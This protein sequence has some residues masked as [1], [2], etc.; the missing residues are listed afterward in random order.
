MHHLV[1]FYKPSGHA[2]NPHISRIGSTR[3]IF[4]LLQVTFHFRSGIIIYLHQCSLGLY[5]RPVYQTCGFYVLKLIILKPLRISLV[6]LGAQTNDSK[7][8]CF[9]GLTFLTLM[10][11]SAGGIL[12]PSHVF[13]GAPLFHLSLPPLLLSPFPFVPLRSLPTLTFPMYQPRLLLCPSISFPDLFP[14]PV[15]PPIFLIFPT[16]IQACYTHSFG[17][18]RASR[19][20]G[21]C[22]SSVYSFEES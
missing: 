7:W 1:I 13:P 12:I 2:P 17:P 18:Q 14:F 15:H 21:A 5:T 22:D 8:H 6:L 10:T 9:T 20:M 19:A 11:I 16:F 3:L 4:R